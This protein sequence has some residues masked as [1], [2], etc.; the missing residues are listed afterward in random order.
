MKTL[1]PWCQ[2]ITD[3]TERQEILD[4]LKSKTFQARRLMKEAE[5][6]PEI[7]SLL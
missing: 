6:L 4:D 2:Q 3:R 1:M 7:K 5:S